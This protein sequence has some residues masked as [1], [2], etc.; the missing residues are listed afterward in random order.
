VDRNERIYRVTGRALLVL[1]ALWIAVMLLALALPRELWKSGAAI[2]IVF[3]CIVPLLF[4]AVLVVG[5]V[6]LV[7]Y[8]RWTG[9]YPYYFLFDKSR[10]QS[11]PI[12]A[13]PNKTGADTKQ[14]R[15]KMK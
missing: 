3:D 5:V 2:I 12:D 9:K 7:S 14:A 11:G 1:L 13:E 8:M 4:V 10:S 6:R 15:E